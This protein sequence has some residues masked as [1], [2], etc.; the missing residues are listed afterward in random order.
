METNLIEDG[1]V[2][3]EQRSV[4]DVG[5]AHHPAQVRGS[6]PRLQQVT[7]R[8]SSA[9]ASGGSQ[10]GVSGEG[11]GTH[12]SWTESVNVGHGPVQRHRVAA[13]VPHDPLEDKVH[14]R[15]WASARFLVLG[16]PGSKRRSKT[17]TLIPECFCLF[18]TFNLQD[19][20]AGQG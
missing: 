3:V 8:S 13:G 11:G 20:P 15:Y 4:A 19:G 6:P 7:R 12:L 14:V 10:E 16:S 9:F 1:G 5:V 2:A 17:Q 18:L